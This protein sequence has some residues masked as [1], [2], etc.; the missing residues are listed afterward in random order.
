MCA[1]LPWVASESTE[2]V[3]PEEI[4]IKLQCVSLCLCTRTHMSDGSWRHTTTVVF[5]RLDVTPFTGHSDPKMI[6]IQS[7]PRGAHTL[8][9]ETNSAMSRSSLTT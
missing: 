1:S 9:V 5:N 2:D 3:S 7:P 4:Y 6:M 8:P